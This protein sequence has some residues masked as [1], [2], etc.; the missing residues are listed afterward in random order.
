MGIRCFQLEYK[1][2][3][4]INWEACI[5]E[6]KNRGCFGHS[7]IGQPPTSILIYI[8]SLCGLLI[9]FWIHQ[10]VWFKHN[11][12]NRLRMVMLWGV[13]KEGP[14]IHPASCFISSTTPFTVTIFISQ[15]GQVFLTASRSAQ[16]RRGLSARII[17]TKADRHQA[18]G[19]TRDGNIAATT[20]EKN[21]NTQV[22]NSNKNPVYLGT[23]PRPDADHAQN[24]NS[25]L[26]LVVVTTSRPEVVRVEVPNDGTHTSMDEE[27]HHEVTVY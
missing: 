13:S 22:T 8:L 12:M 9:T 20:S 3:L 23:V 5:Q 19:P 16:Y 10:L 4:Q 2:N 17:R 21:A 26:K 24:Q 15:L 25:H 18:R 1:W 6:S 14:R 7:V 11:V 27:L